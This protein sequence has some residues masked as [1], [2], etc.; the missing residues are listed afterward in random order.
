M[1]TSMLAAH[2]PMSREEA[3]QLVDMGLDLLMP[4]AAA[5]RDAAHGMVVS[6]SR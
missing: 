5:R 4:A 6:Y 3:Y 1:T 2:H